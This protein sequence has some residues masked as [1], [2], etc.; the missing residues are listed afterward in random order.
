M[1]VLDT[2]MNLLFHK[3]RCSVPAERR[4]L[5][6]KGCGVWNWVSRVLSYSFYFRIKGVGIGIDLCCIIRC[7]SVFARGNPIYIYRCYSS[8]QTPNAAGHNTAVDSAQ[9]SNCS[10]LWNSNDATFNSKK[11]QSLRHQTDCWT[12]CW[13]YCQLYDIPLRWYLLRKICIFLQFI[14]IYHFNIPSISCINY[15][16]NFL[17]MSKVTLCIIHCISLPVVAV[18]SI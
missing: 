7:P 16:Y 6:Q 3:H 10:A 12:N 9:F 17:A 13:L 2:G 4:W 8:T 18:R 15:V 11:Y 14:A 5:L 1:A